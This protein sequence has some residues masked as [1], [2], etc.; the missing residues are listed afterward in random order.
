MTVSGNQEVTQ[1]ETG[2]KEDTI[3]S[4]QIENLSIISR[5]SPELSQIPPAVVAPHELNRSRSALAAPQAPAGT[6]T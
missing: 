3:T 2:A 4:K 5:S 6:T 1:R